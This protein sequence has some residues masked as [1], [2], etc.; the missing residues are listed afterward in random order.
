MPA[1]NEHFPW[2]GHYGNYDFFE[3]NMKSHTKV[4]SVEANG[5]GLY[6]L[7]LKD[8]KTIRVFICECYSY[9]LAEYRETCDKLGQLDVIIINSNWCSY[10]IDAK[11][12]CRSTMVGLFSITQFMASL[13][14]IDFWM[15]LDKDQK[16]EFS[17]KGLLNG[18][19]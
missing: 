1:K 8:H 4:N 9:G 18:D 7:T 17:E 5:Q 10:T 13:N 6:K 19:C 14:Q 15:Y 11:V 16:K 2:L 3:Q 12:H